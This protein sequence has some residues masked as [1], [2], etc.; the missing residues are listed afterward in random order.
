MDCYNILKSYRPLKKDVVIYNDIFFL[1]YKNKFYNY[2]YTKEQLL[3]KNVLSVTY[4]LSVVFLLWKRY[5][6]GVEESNAF[7]FGT[8]LVV[9][10][11][12]EGDTLP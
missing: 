8:V 5:N 6:Q 10:V 4:W 12:N 1:L 11:L 2:F 7:T 3:S 9:N